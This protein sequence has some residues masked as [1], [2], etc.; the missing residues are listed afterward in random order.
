MTRFF[1]EARAVNIVSHP[2]IVGSFDYGQLK[3]AQRT[4]SWNTSTVRRSRRESKRARGLAGP[5]ALRIGRQI[6]ATLAAA[7]HQ[8]IIHRDMKPDNIMIVADQKHR[9]VSG[10]RSW[11]LASPRSRRSTSRASRTRA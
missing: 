5:D 4:S 3:T 8:G 9:A 10:P 2:G 11:T 7:A 1:N 6:A